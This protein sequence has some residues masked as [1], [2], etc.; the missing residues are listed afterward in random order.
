MSQAKYRGFISSWGVDWGFIGHPETR[1]QAFA[2]ITEFLDAEK[3]GPPKVGEHVKFDIMID[4]KKLRAV[5]IVRLRHGN[6]N[7]GST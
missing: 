5:R 1:A 7:E 2:H 3:L 4:R 6:K